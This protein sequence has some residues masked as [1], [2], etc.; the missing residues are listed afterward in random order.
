MQ[1]IRHR[2]CHY[3]DQQERHTKRHHPMPLKRYRVAKPKLV[4]KKFQFFSPRVFVTP[5][6]LY[7]KAGDTQRPKWQGRSCPRLLQNRAFS[8]EAKRVPEPAR[9]QPSR[10]RQSCLSFGRPLV[11]AF[12]KCTTGPPS[13]D[14]FRLALVFCGAARLTVAG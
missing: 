9:A 6:A 5:V 3:D 8:G 10:T 13:G 11:C 4:A 1:D 7:N 12:H 14:P 2:Y